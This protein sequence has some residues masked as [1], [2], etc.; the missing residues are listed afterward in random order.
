[1]VTIEVLKFTENQEK[2][3]TRLI[4]T[5]DEC[6]SEKVFGETY[7]EIFNSIMQF[8][9]GYLSRYNIPFSAT[10][11]RLENY[12]KMKYD[13]IVEKRCQQAASLNVVNDIEFLFS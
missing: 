3:Y 6:F 9:V 12:A 10:F 7:A 4:K 2:I 1:M 8:S 11:L 5:L 13:E